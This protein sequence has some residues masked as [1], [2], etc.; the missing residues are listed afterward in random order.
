VLFVNGIPFGV[1]ECKSPLLSEEFAIS[2]HLRNQSAEYIPQL[3]KFAQI[4]LATNKNSVKYATTGAA[5]K[6][7]C[8]WKE[9]YTD[10]LNEQLTQCV[11]D[12]VP[13][14]QDKAL[15]SLYSP[16]RLLKFVRWFTLY[17]ANVKKIARYQQFFAVEAII[18]TIETDDAVTGNRQSGVIW[19]TQGS[20]KSL[21]MVMLARYILEKVRGGKIILVTDRTELDRQIEQT[22]SHT[23]LKPSRATSGKNLID[24]INSGKTDIVTAIIN[25][26]NTA[27]NRG[28][29]V[30]SRD[31]F[32]LVDESH[33][34]N[35]G[36]L[37]AKMRLVFPNACYIGFTG[38]PLMKNEKN[39]MAKFGKLI[40]KYTIS[41][42]VNDKA[43]VPLIY[44]GR[45]VEQ[46][47]DEA[48]IDLW[49]EQITKRLSDKQKEDLRNRWA[50]LRSLQSTDARIRRI[51]L[52]INTHFVDGYKDTNFK[53]MLACNFKRDA[54]RYL[55][56]F[57]QLGDVSAAV[58]ISSP[59]MREGYED[60]DESIDDKV[61]QYW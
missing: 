46:N 16:E 43:I 14:R 35:Y 39:T 15:V 36:A 45:F 33:M 41:D 57:E 18:R 51:A 17:D 55:E 50:Q 28:M 47:V 40:H 59:D 7:W 2:Q 32:V 9:E 44:E 10:W 3:Y 27:E 8:T 48:N 6:Y 60:I 22:F 24:I 11:V 29:K 12:R 1:I 26:F 20:G 37:D 4:L 58:V 21:T 31:V 54:M 23:R 52:D 25:K 61:L 53:A 5:K 13:T 38:T 30:E 19:H 49:F 42:G 34:T 56:C